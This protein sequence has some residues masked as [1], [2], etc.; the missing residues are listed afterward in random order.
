M[1]LPKPIRQHVD[2][3]YTGKNPAR[4]AA[5]RKCWQQARYRSSVLRGI[6]QKL[7]RKCVL[8]TRCQKRR[9]RATLAETHPRCHRCRPRTDTPRGRPG[10]TAAEWLACVRSAGARGFSAR[11]KPEL[12]KLVAQGLVACKPGTETQ[13]RPRWVS[14]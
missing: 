1:T 13:R 6:E 4:Q 3:R 2:Q 10:Y 7:G 8:C 11:A 5:A 9:A 14:A 12:L